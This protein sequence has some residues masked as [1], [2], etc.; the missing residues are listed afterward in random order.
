MGISLLE[1]LRFVEGELMVFAAFWFAVGAFDEMAIDFVWLW[2]FVKGRTQAQS[3]PA[4][5]ETRALT[6][7]IAVMV[8]AWQEPQVI[9]EMIA[10]TLS[11]WPQQTLTMYVGCYCNDAATLAAAVGGAQGDRRLRIVIH[12]RAGPTS[13]ADCLNRLYRAV[14][15]DEE[16]RG[17]AFAGVVLHD[18]EDMVHPVALPLI[19]YM[20][21]RVDYVQ[22]PV[23]PEPQAHSPWVA[24][25][26]TDEFTE[27]HAKTMVVR[28]A[29][30]A[31]I[32]SAGV[33]FGVARGA[34]DQLAA[35]RALD[36]GEGP[37]EP[38]CLTEDYELGVL[39]SRLGA[40]GRFV[41][42]RDASGSLVATRAFFPSTIPDAVRQ[43]TRWIHGIALQ[44]WARLGWPEKRIDKW[45]TVRDRRG[46]LLALVLAAAY[47][48]IVIEGL[49]LASGRGG[50]APTDLQP[51]VMRLLLVVTL[52]AV[53][54]RTGWRFAFTASEYGFTE[55]C[56][57]VLRI[58]VANL[59]AILAG[60][61]AFAAYVGTLRGRAIHWDKTAHDA[62]P[63]AASA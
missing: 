55:G 53:I 12:D 39:L 22:L 57:A 46:P 2:L 31:A 26:Y 9:G 18:A 59:V 50:L 62:H 35:L 8:A 56:R 33:G 61:R 5:Y 23:R 41:R 38:K 60:R 52:F 21:E 63:A 6:G 48:L 14:I 54:W 16:R 15:A 44:C 13:K 58:P 20:L 40:R 24:G 43:K 34:L 30:G 51:P 3:L 49:M 17:V 11:A 4:G 1:N 37:F 47:L 28:D 45:M 42:A 27:A 7:R 19:D 36:G 29:L 25:H 32:P 10:H